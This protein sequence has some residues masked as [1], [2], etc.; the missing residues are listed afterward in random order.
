MKKYSLILVLLILSL[1]TGCGPGPMES[2]RGPVNTPV[3]KPVILDTLNDGSNNVLFK[4]FGFMYINH[5]LQTIGDFIVTNKGVYFVKWNPSSYRYSTAYQVKF[6]NIANISNDTIHRTIGF[7]SNLIVIEDKRGS[8]IG[9]A[10]QQ[11]TAAKNI[12]LNSKEREF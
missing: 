9:F 2:F 7:D 5:D 11:V 12:I 3:F 10:L 4:D 8:K 1:F 6:K